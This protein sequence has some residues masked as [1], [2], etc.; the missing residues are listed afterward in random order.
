M[1]RLE[2]KI[3]EYTEYI[4]YQKGRIAGH[5]GVGF[6]IK[7][8]L[9]QYIQEIIGISDRLAILNLKLPNYKKQWSVI[10][11]YSPTE[12]AEKS[13]LDS[14]YEELAQAI[15][16]HR[17]NNILLMGDF[18]AQV[19]AR[20]NNEE[21]VLGMFGHGKRSSNGQQLIE[22]LMEHN[23]TV[24]NSLFKKNPKNKWTWVSPNGSYK[25]EIDYI[26]SNNPKAFTDTTVITKLNFNTNHRMVRSSLKI[27]PDKPSR[28]H[29]KGQGYNQLRD[30]E[31]QNVM[32]FKEIKKCINETAN[33]TLQCE[34]LEKHITNHYTVKRIQKTHKY[35]LSDHT[36]QLINKRK[37]YISQQT[38][39]DTVKLIA[40]ISK[41][42]RESIRKDRKIKRLQTL[43]YHI[44]K[45]GAVKKALKELREAGKQWIPKLKQK[46]KTVTKR[47]NINELATNF[48]TQLYA[49]QETNKDNHTSHS[50]THKVPESIVEAV[51][52]ILP[53]EV[54]K[55]IKSQKM[56]KSP[57]PGK[58]TNEMMKG[59]LKELTPILTNIFNNILLSG[60]IPIQWTKSHIILIHKKGDKENIENYRPISLMSNVYKILA[61]II[62]DRMSP[63]LDEQ[64]PVEQAGFRRGFSTIDHIHTV[65]QILE[66]Y[67]EY[68]KRV[69]IAFVDYTKAFDSLNH[70]YIW[71]TLEKQGIPTIYINIIKNIYGNSQARIR[72]ETLGKE[73]LIERGVR[74]GDPL[75]PKL[76]S[77]VLE[78][79]FRNLNWED[80]GLNIDG[81]NL[82]HLRFADD[83]VLFD[84]KPETLEKMLES[85]NEESKKVGLAMNYTKTK[86]MTN[87]TKIDIRVSQET[88]EYVDEYTYLGQLISQRIN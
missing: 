22:F 32:N 43:E 42:I 80:F 75:S 28:K 34:I 10:Q 29:I 20:Q 11:V 17:N 53:C 50:H 55:A 2:E 4:L 6:L 83:L 3:E 46:E 82:T 74:Q 37:E 62:L 49:K 8:H 71:D 59:S 66:K 47:K 56:G 13:I 51:P 14:F 65:K 70:K 38:N 61:K 41:S 58:I 16:R 85:L 19:G 87:S 72:L 84:E 15:R 18:N 7:Q 40:E 73:F 31:E 5:Y 26:I 27:I 35:K 88:L 12:Q 9:K 60:N 64:Q 30:H 52:E 77:A 25:N 79:I 67:N 76:F 86:L 24:L 68:N 45:R 78:N 21:Y 57:G 69:Y 39:R 23:L 48:Y 1:R 63:M 54:E 33:T 81:S 36:L 44:Q